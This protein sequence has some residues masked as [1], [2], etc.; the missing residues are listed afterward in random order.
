M[1]TCTKC[2]IENR[3]GETYCASCGQP[4]TAGRFGSSPRT[5]AQSTGSYTPRVTVAPREEP[6]YRPPVQSASA[7]GASYRPPVQS[8][9]AEGASYRPPVQSASAEG[10]SYRPPV[11]SAP[12]ASAAYRAPSRAPLPMRAEPEEIRLPR[13]PY[14]AFLI[15]LGVIWC[16]LL[17]ALLGLYVA[18]NIETLKS[19]VML[20]FTAPGKELPDVAGYALLGVTALLAWLLALMPGLCLAASGKRLRLAVIRNELL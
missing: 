3:D 2:H 11:Q 14:A 16:A 17:T 6:A 4:R 20:L 8:T 9:S 18:L 13:T 1:W 10:A 15:T 7:E 19:A 5:L 12:A